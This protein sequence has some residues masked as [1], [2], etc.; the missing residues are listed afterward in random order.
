MF[1][2]FNIKLFLLL[3]THAEMYTSIIH[4]AQNWRK[5][6]IEKTVPTSVQSVTGSNMRLIILE[7]N[8]PIYTGISKSSILRTHKIYR[9]P[10]TDLWI[11]PLWKSLIELRNNQW[12][13]LYLSRWLIT[14]RLYGS[15]FFRHTHH[16]CYY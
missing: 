12:E 11:I 9:M 16:K 14:E 7:S 5:W 15:I 10:P 1:L 13:V 4:K 8:V 2:S 3:W 6:T